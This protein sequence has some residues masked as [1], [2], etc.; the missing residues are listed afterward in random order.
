MIECGD[1]DNEEQ[2]PK[3]YKRI[4][5]NSIQSP[6]T[7][8][9]C[10]RVF[11]ANRKF[12]KPAV[13]RRRIYDKLPHIFNNYPDFLEIFKKYCSENLDHLTAESIHQ[14]LFKTG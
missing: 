14:Y 2:A 7:I 9:K 13:G 12:L 1:G 8:M 6:I 4:T 10:L 3:K 5:S 11:R